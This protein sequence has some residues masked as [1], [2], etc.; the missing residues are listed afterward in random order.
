MNFLNEKS[1]INLIKESGKDYLTNEEINLFKKYYEWQNKQNFLSYN[2]AYVA[3]KINESMNYSLIQFYQSGIFISNLAMFN[4]L[5]EDIKFDNNII[6]DYFNY[7]TK[8][9]RYV[10]FPI[11]DLLMLLVI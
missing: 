11:K 5:V 3:K 1:L 2:L 9:T 4:Q 8:L 7:L 10:V 6:T